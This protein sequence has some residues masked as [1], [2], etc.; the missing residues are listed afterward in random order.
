MSKNSSMVVGAA[1]AV[2]TGTRMTEGG[3]YLGQKIYEYSE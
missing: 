1:G 3:E 2:E